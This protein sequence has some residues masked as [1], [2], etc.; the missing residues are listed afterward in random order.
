[1][2][3]YDLSSRASN[4]NYDFGNAQIVI[5][6]DFYQLGPPT[7]PGE[8]PAD[9]QAWEPKKEDPE[10]NE[11]GSCRFYNSSH[12]MRYINSYYGSNMTVF[13]NT[14]YSGRLTNAHHAKIIKKLRLGIRDKE[15]VKFL[16]SKRIVV[17]GTTASS[18]PLLLGYKYLML[19][20]SKKLAEYYNDEYMKSVK[21]SKSSVK[22]MSMPPKVYENPNNAIVLFGAYILYKESSFGH[23]VSLKINLRVILEKTIGPGRRILSGSIGTIICFRKVTFECADF[24]KSDITLPVVRFSKSLTAIV[25]PSKID[26]TTA[27]LPLES[28]SH[29]HSFEVAMPLKPYWATTVHKI[30][31][32]SLKHVAIDL[33]RAQSPGQLY[34]AISRTYDIGCIKITDPGLRTVVPNKQARGA[35]A[36]LNRIKYAAKR[37]KCS[38]KVS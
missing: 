36:M 16:R 13:I 19:T 9:T 28:G 1:M 4:F 29:S 15:V 27:P 32:E 12:W 30:Q 34:S 38:K 2:I 20:T 5:C 7:A 6:G 25:S 14:G 3:S 22:Y 37:S 26:V 35:Y 24:L 21:S 10:A 33:T 18:M 11:A 23:A 31:G 17:D 8:N